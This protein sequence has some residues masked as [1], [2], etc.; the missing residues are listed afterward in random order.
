MLEYI[1]TY[2]THQH[3]ICVPAPSLRSSAEQ[4]A[5]AHGD[6]QAEI[7][8]YPQGVAHARRAFAARAQPL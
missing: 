2:L 8:T 6:P 5:A 4:A 3:V 1:R 7:T